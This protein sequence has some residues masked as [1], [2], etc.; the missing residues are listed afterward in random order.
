MEMKIVN[1]ELLNFPVD[2]IY[3]KEG[4][5]VITSSE[6]TKKLLGPLVNIVVQGDTKEKAIQQFFLHLRLTLNFYKKD[7]DKYRKYAPLII[8]EWNQ[9]GGS[10]F[11]IFGINVYFRYGKGMKGGFYIPFTKLNIMISNLHK[12]KEK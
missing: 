6:E 12:T 2:I 1:T 7:A 5:W 3:T 9:I 10:W 11:Q 4:H 8:G